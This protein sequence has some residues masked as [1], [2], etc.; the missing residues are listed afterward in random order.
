MD[1]REP[2]PLAAG[3][4]QS[5]GPSTSD[6]L[7][8][9]PLFFLCSIPCT[10]TFNPGVT[11]AQAKVSLAG[12]LHDI[13]GDDNVLIE[14]TLSV[15]VDICGDSIIGNTP[16]ETCDPPNQPGGVNGNT[17]RANCT[18]CGDGV[19]D[20]EEACDDGNT[21]NEDTCR[22]NCTLIECGDGIL[23]S[24]ETCD[25]PGSFGNPGD[26]SNTCR[27]DCTFCG[28]GIQNT[29]EDCDDGNQTSS[30]GCEADCTVLEQELGGC[31]ITA[32]GIT[33][34]GVTDPNE[35]ADTLRAT[36]GG[37]VGAPCGCI[38]CFDE[39]DH[40]QGNWQHSRK[41]RKGNFHA[42]D[43]NS[44]VCGCDGVFDGE[45]CNPGDRE[46]GPE[47]RKAPANMA[48]WSG[49]GDFNPTRGK[50]TIRAAFRVEVED[51]SEP[52]VG[53]L[54]PDDVYRI[55]IWVPG[56]GESPEVLAAMACCTISNLNLDIRPPNI[57]DGG[58]LIHGNIQIHPLLPNTEDGTCPVPD[59]TCQQ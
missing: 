31:R 49:V 12:V 38:G 24:G 26:G 32:G 47:P 46:P 6:F 56:Q 17:C 45:L 30:D 5:C 42:K 7:I 36:F 48:C 18:V 4:P 14:R 35:Y 41:S 20:S 2:S 53:K 11:S 19:K 52:G 8:P 39:F 15:T 55:R 44:L 21:N 50:K 13:E 9:T 28:D 1:I 29:G 22:N 10:V 33:P 51:R 16:G 27:T 43:Y 54:L 3:A 23:D 58:A 57:D 37:Q 59:G 25:P 40:I 34:D